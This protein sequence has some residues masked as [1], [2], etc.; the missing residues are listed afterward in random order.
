MPDMTQDQV[1]ATGFT[2]DEIAELTKLV[3]PPDQQAALLEAGA[4]GDI[5]GFAK[6]VTLSLEFSSTKKRDDAKELIRKLCGDEKR[7]A[8]DLVLEAAKAYAAT[9]RKG[10]KVSAA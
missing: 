6:S 1:L 10:R 4:S 3:L 8:G 7:K 5:T 9:P 2:S